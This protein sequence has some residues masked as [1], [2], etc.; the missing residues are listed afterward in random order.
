MPSLRISPTL[1]L[2]TI[3][4][5]YAG[6]LHGQFMRQAKLAGDDSVL[7][8]QP[9]CTCP[10]IPVAQGSWVALSADGNT[11]IEYG[12]G[13]DNSVGGAAWIF[14]RS[15]GVWIQ[16]G[17]KLIGTGAVGQSLRTVGSV[18]I[19]ADGN[20][21][22]VGRSGD[23]NA[24]GAVWV[25]TR[26]DGVWSQ[27]G[28]KLVGSGSVG[29]YV[30]FG[31]AIALSADGNTAVIAGSSDNNLTGA[32]WVFTRTNGVWSQQ[33]EKLV[34]DGVSGRL[35][36]GAPAI[37]ADGN[38]ILFGS[39]GPLPGGSGNGFN[40][41]FTRQNG[42]WKQEA[43]LVIT[44]IGGPVYQ[45]LASGLS[46]DGNTAIV[47]GYNLVTFDAYMWVFVRANGVWKQQGQTQIASQP[48]DGNLPNVYVAVSADGNTAALNTTVWSRDS[49][50]WTQTGVLAAPIGPVATSA[51]GATIMVG[52][53][54]DNN[55]IGEALV[56]IDRTAPLR[57]RGPIPTHPGRQ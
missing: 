2:L 13:D 19:S 40:W 39:P 57:G 56:F 1:L 10:G 16:Q 5:G 47:G 27:Q 29:P 41:V 21:A 43:S 12:Y 9:F 17:P 28:D 50:A 14:T 6:N 42:T 34:A 31:Q 18:A 46:A 44:D 54:T 11:G 52:N 23:N 51:D 49:D 33:G 36:Q 24:M 37:S 32:L 4:F 55:G 35:A 7:A 45:G 22:L 30:G 26:T 8:P 25:F 3:S 38:T 53:P 15:N 20:T 48:H